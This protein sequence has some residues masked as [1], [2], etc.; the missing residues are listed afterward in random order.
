MPELTTCL[1]FDDQ[2]EQAAQHYVSIFP[3]S[4][5]TGVTRWA[6]EGP[7]PE[8]SVLTVD[9]TLDGRRFVGLNGGPQFTF[10]EAV[11]VQVH[12]DTQEEV[13]YYWNALLDGGEES[14]CGWLKDR[15]G[16]SWQIVPNILPEYL[17]GPDRA[18]AGRVM[19]AV[20]GMKKLDVAGLRQA[21]AG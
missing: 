13:D 4:R 11:S 5:I 20:L 10:S 17:S 15:F 3:N 14:V 9:F 8:G 6:P 7:G 21:A 18:A 16:F 19:Q 2:A 12:V 1:W